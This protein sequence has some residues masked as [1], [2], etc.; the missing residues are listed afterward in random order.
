MGFAIAFFLAAGLTMLSFAGFYLEDGLLRTI[1]L[2]LGIVTFLFVAL[3]IG[4]AKMMKNE[5]K[6]A[7][8]QS[9]SAKVFSKLSEQEVSGMGGTTSTTNAYFVVFELPDGKRMKFKTELAQYGVIAE[10]DTGTLEYKDANNELHLV[11]FTR[12]I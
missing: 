6:N 1:L 4:G 9:T 10:G 12:Q 3:L 8:I 7:P 11:D 5:L 2:V